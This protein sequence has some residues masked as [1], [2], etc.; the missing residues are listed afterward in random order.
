[1]ETTA[2]ERIK[3]FIE[4]EGISIREFERRANLSNG[5]LKSL[6]K[7]PTSDKVEDIIR[8]FPA[9]NPQW[10]LT[11]EGSML[12]EKE[13]ETPVVTYDKGRP[14]YDVDFRGG[15]DSMFNDQSI[16]PEYNID[17]RPCNKEGVVWCNLSGH[18]M[19]P[20]I[21]SGDIIALREVMDWQSYLPLGE[22]Y[23]IVTAN[24]LRTVKIVRKGSDEAHLRLVPVNTE[25]YDEDEIL[26]ADIQRVFAVLGCIKR[27]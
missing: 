11:G 5:Y 23:A 24:D 16:T 26:K 17:F 27:M 8:A 3:A 15:F 12:L 20:M 21:N 18:S 19:E 6:R 25:G 10:L 1:M 7:S 4:K 2:K 13:E 14:Y 9:L 22:V